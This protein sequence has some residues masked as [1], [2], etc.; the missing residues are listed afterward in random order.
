M[1]SLSLFLIA[2]FCVSVLGCQDHVVFSDYKHFDEGWL[3]SDTLHFE[4][5][6]P[7]TIQPYQLFFNTR[8]NQAYAFNNLYL[9]ATIHFPNGKQIGDTLEY[10]MAH[11]DGELMGQ[12]F[13]SVKDSK[14]WYKSNVIFKEPGRYTLEVKQAMRKMES[15]HPL[16]TLQGVMDFGLHVETSLKR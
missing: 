1:R 5:D 12:G 6:A 7:D 15:I 2:V 13:G 3:Q 4:F 14:L 9:I 10:E 16:D 11:P 8:L